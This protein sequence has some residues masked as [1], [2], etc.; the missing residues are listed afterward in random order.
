[1][2][3]SNQSD[4]IAA[5][6]A[7]DAGRV[8]ELLG[9]DPSLATARDEEGVSALMLSRYRSAREVTDALLAAD[10][11]LDVY[12]AASLGYIDRLRER[13][14][15]DPSLATAFSADGF[16]ALHFTAFFGK[17]EAARVLIDAGAGVNVYSRND[18]NVQPLHSAAAGRHH[19]VCRILLA[20][21]AYVNAKQQA[22]Y[23]P[24]HEAAQ[25]GDDELVE[26]FLSAGAD[27]RARLDDGKTPAE[28]A[29][30]SGH[31]DVAN[32][33][34]VVAEADDLPG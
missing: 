13:L 6:N 14:E 27:V 3:M 24:L 19:E 12:E 21:A 30:A 25:H 8:T 22:G 1:M 10:P 15:D 33:L 18:F 20:A 34:R 2:T 29:E 32:R 16:T 28:V 7:D 26:L 23:T 9:Q 31:P 11:E 5:V 4:M 17:A